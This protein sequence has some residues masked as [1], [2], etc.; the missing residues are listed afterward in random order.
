MSEQQSNYKCDLRYQES[1]CS[2][3]DDKECTSRTE[4]YRRSR[5]ATAQSTI[6]AGIVVNGDNQFTITRHDAGM[7]ETEYGVFEH[8]NNLC[9]CPD[10]ETATRIM[11]ALVKRDRE[12]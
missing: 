2:K 5:P 1:Q 8:N 9:M 12:L 4:K 6:K 7:G 3:C 10:E 11:R